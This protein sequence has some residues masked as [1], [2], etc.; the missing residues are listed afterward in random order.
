MDYNLDYAFPVDIGNFT[1]LVDI[2][3]TTVPKDVMP[4]FRYKVGGELDHIR[5]NYSWLG[6]YIDYF[7]LYPG[8]S[9]GIHTDGYLGDSFRAV[10]CNIPII[11]PLKT[12]T[13]WYVMPDDT[14]WYD[15]WAIDK[16][17]ST[18]AYKN[19]ISLWARPEYKPLSV[20]FELETVEP[21]IFNTKKPHSIK[22]KGTAKR[23]MASWHT[24]FETYEQAREYFNITNR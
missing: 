12:F 2:Y 13:S 15:P 10:V 9:I 17:G 5:R 23:V 20:P 6:D 11:N 14:E 7:V 16:E 19:G 8:T 21:I 24:K 3:H 22:N 18:S 4:V 1:K